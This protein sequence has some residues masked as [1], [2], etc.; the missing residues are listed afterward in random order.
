[1]TSILFA[2]GLRP[3]VKHQAGKHDQ[4]RHAGT[5]AASTVL[6]EGWSQRSQEDRIA[7]A[8]ARIRE[9]W[10]AGKSDA[11]LREYAARSLI[12]TEI[13]DGPNGTTVTVD[14]SSDLPQERVTQAMNDISTLQ[15]IAPV[16]DL[17]V[18]VSNEPF[19]RY[20]IPDSTKGFVIMGEEKIHLRPTALSEGVDL[21]SG[22][23]M[24]VFG[25]QP[26]RYSLVH[27]YG[28]VLDKRDDYDAETDL[29]ESY[30]Y[31][32][33]SRYAREGDPPGHAGREA[34]AEAWTG[35]VGSQGRLDQGPES[36]V[37]YYA[38]KYGWESGEGGSMPS[39]GFA[40]AGK[41]IIL[42]DSF[43]SEGA[44]VIE[45]DAEDVEKH[46]KGKHDQ[47]SHAGTR[48]TN[49][50]D[51]T[52]SRGEQDVAYLTG[53]RI[54]PPDWMGPAPTRYVPRRTLSSRV[55][56]ARKKIQQWR[57]R[58]ESKRMAEMTPAEVDRVSRA[59]RRR[60]DAK[61]A[62]E[63]KPPLYDDMEKRS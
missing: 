44:S 49:I 7:E 25:S 29:T 38:D 30:F 34:F 1:M 50:L 4:K 36:F 26:H 16:Q 37:G 41:R 59:N 33:G 2:P 20:G 32:G 39:A 18:Q 51:E 47:Q 55:K 48:Q 17:E 35:W 53:R 9:D 52:M 8:V 61:R 13:Y 40:K 12:G 62:A 5:R 19:D 42:T 24:P 27:E 23:L 3:V 45:I 6:P 11:E 10:G 60:V 63:G 22:T 57:Q 31:T 43:T 54:A 28:H 14:K 46:Y 21:E 58:R 15:Q 56:S